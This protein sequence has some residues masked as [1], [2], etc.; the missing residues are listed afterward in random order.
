MEIKSYTR[1][2][3]KMK[4]TT[5]L[6]YLVLALIFAIAGST[7]DAQKAELVIQS[8]HT[9]AV[10][11]VVFS[12]D[13]KRF[14][15]GSVDR[16][17]KLWDITT[18]QE[19]KTFRGHTRAVNSVAFSPDGKTLASGSDDKTIK[20]WDITTG[21]ELKTFKG[22]TRAV[23]SAAFSPDGKTL[24][25][26]SDDKTIKLWDR[27]TGLELKTLKEHTS[28][29][30]S[31]AFSPDGKTLASGSTDKTIKLWDTITGQEL[32]TLKEHTS[33]VVS[34]AFSL[35][36]KTLASGSSDKTIKL[37]DITTGQELKTL[38]GHTSVVVSVAFSPDG[39]TLASGSSDKTIKLWDIETGK[40][41]NTLL[42]HTS[43]VVSVAFSSDGKR[44]ASSGYSDRTI[45][46]WDINTGQELKTLKGHTSDVNSVFFSPDG[47]TLASRSQ[48]YTIQLWDI[49][50]GTKLKTLKG[51]TNLIY[52]V[53]FSPDGKTLASGSYDKTIK[54]WDIETGKE[55][56]TLLGHTSYVA[57]VAFSPDGKTLA[58]GSDDKTIRLWDKNT[59]QE[60]KTIKGHT[61]VV[62]SVAFSPDGRT[63]A[64]RSWDK[65]I[66]LWD[67]ETGNELKTLRG[68]TSFVNSVS[69]SPDGK[70]LTSGS[71]DKTIKLWDIT[72]GQELKTFKGHT[73]AVISAAFSP[74]GKTLASGSDD[75]TIKL[76][77]PVSG[78]QLKS[79]QTDD[80][81]TVREVSNI[82]PDIYRNN[83]LEPIT[84]DGRFQIKLGENGRFNLHQVKTGKLLVSL[85]GLDEHDWVVI[86]PDGRFDASPNAQKL[87]H[88]VIG[89]EPID[90]GQI[91]DRY[92]T[93]NL[94][95]RILKGEDLDAT[96][97]V[98][99]F[100]SDELYP[101]AEYETL[102]KG[103]TSLT[104]KL[105]NRG[106][107]IGPVQVFVNS[108]EFL[109]DARPVGFDPKARQATLKVDFSKANFIP[110]EKND[111]KI[112]TRN[113]S[114]W[115]RSRGSD[116]IYL[117]TRKK[118]EKP[119]EFYA[120]IG[121]VSDY[122]NNGLNLRYSAKDARDFAKA[123]ELGAVRLFGKDR[124]H[125]R[126]LASGGDQG[127]NAL[128]G[129]DSKQLAPTKENFR[130]AF[131]EFQTAKPSDI[132]VVYLAGHGVSINKGGDT[133]DTYLYLTK[134]AVTTDKF[135]L[136][137]EK[138]RLSTTISSEE[139][140]DWIREVPALKR[141]MILD[142]CAAGAVEASLVKAR[143]LSP[144]Q[145]KA[146]D[147]MKDRTGFFVLMGSAADKVS[148][149]ATRYGQGLLT[150]SLLQGMSGAKLRNGEYA[151]VRSLFSYAEDVVV[152][153]A[154]GIG[155]I[156][157]PRIIAPTESRSFDIGQFTTEEKSKFTL[158]KV[159][160]LILQPK[161][162]N[163]KLKFDNLGISTLLAKA[164]RNESSTASRGGEQAKLVFV[165]AEEM[166]DAITPAGTYEVNGDRIKLTL[167]LVRN[168]NPVKKLFVE[169]TLKNKEELAQ[170]IVRAINENVESLD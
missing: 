110:G 167:I 119:Q 34:V 123:L 149:E 129:K 51:H 33:I 137:D 118:N 169:G 127:G 40:E 135:R 76:W 11:S 80:P 132:F 50:A 17:I 170:K 70:T 35:D 125:I 8:G 52:S 7:V 98:S 25:S 55:Q 104:V 156:Q 19:L 85:I 109:A 146:L 1:K 108:S 148:Y 128:S 66:R 120:I 38:K 162:F 165:E 163:E 12:P 5:N 112:V 136:R 56:N 86:D 26:G 138:L 116:V 111:I 30:V 72:T 92:Y 97:K 29:V 122:E 4:R 168:N 155:G 130:R 121:G 153:M 117:D 53:S 36:G 2:G 62:N 74:D 140:A 47:K 22:H 82:V 44:I 88:Y 113:E 61:R 101:T 75:K 49:N 37:W 15:S 114:G 31:V 83:P 54:L 9:S 103:Q 144:D 79:Y 161:L 59:G 131:K 133:G 18:G 67:I 60:L 150:Y 78:K 164:L 106:G 95:Q 73:R 105:R 100:T 13:G 93:P 154:K 14:A 159:K 142:T 126:L 141:A 41:Q 89:L 23:I 68:H 71:S 143:D 158:A 45:R 10:V 96:R 63:L 152:E 57:S 24:A 157:Q 58:S 6:M 139:L 43:Y 124:V 84:L 99:P 102:K 46:L 87:M 160:Q 28:I 134:E 65:T 48:D 39:K 107:G 27:N 3:A 64:S 90:F 81:A 42:G 77:D 32:K 151:D 16:T 166:K 91:K 145:I 94:L 69:F 147:R 115:L 20:L 21:Q